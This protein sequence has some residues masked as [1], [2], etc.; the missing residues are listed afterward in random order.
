MFHP[1]QSFPDD[2]DS[3]FSPPSTWG[4]NL[5]PPLFLLGTT[6]YRDLPCSHGCKHVELVTHRLTAHALC[7]AQ[8]SFPYLWLTTGHFHLKL[9]PVFETQH[10]LAAL[11]LS[12]TKASSLSQFLVSAYSPCLSHSCLKHWNH[13]P[14]ASRAYLCSPG[15]FPIISDTSVLPI[16]FF[17]TSQFL[18][19][20]FLG[21]PS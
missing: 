8:G 2:F 4:L 1:F 14:S 3:F 10:S 15:A 20:S 18:S 11:A 6:V 17:K 13:L 19:I 7:L 5:D 12:P 16:S 9:L 21:F